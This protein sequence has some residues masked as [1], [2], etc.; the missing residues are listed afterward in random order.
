MGLA[1]QHAISNVTKVNLV[2]G[3]MLE[4]G[5]LIDE[6][7]VHGGAKVETHVHV[8]LANRVAIEVGGGHVVRR[9][10]LL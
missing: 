6:M 10:R 7:T 1:E 4:C 2:T 9:E 3:S 8:A 5:P